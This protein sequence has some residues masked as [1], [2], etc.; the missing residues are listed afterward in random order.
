MFEF[1]K[2]PPNF[3]KIDNMITVEKT[4]EKLTTIVSK[5]VLVKAHSSNQGRKKPKKDSSFL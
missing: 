4:V 5:I 2:I 3:N 1:G